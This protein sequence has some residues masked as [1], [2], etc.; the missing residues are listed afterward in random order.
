MNVLPIS[1]EPRQDT[2]KKA[3]KHIRRNG[4]IPAVIYSKNGVKHFTT[5]HN[6]VKSII[7]TP[8]LKLAEIELDGQSFRALV[9]NIDFHPVTE[10][11]LHIDFLELIDGQQIKAEIPLKFTGESP[12]VKNGGKLFRA[13]RKVKVKT[14]PESL[15]DELFV[16][17]SELE[18]GDSVKVRDIKVPEGV[19]ILM[20]DGIPVGGVQVPRAL[21]SEEELAAEEM[22][23]E[24]GEE[25]TE[26]AEG[27]ESAAGEG[28]EA[29]DEA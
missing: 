18:L 22:E 14:T 9:K 24:E 19:E 25:G 4:R 11:I 8:D 7:F 28:G 12:G 1:V 13:V 3:A 20:D 15:V 23:G 6:A 27:G 29:K 17:I 21:K 26:G 5:T 2:G 10:D 16:D